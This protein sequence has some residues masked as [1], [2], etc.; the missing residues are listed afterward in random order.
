VWSQLG[1]HNVLNG[2]AAIAAARHAGVPVMVAIEALA[3]FRGVKRRLEL[4]GVVDRIAVYDDFAHHPTAIATTLA[5]LRARVGDDRVIAVLEPR[6]NT[7]RMG[8]FRDAL[9]A[10]LREAD[11]VVCYQA[12]DL[13]WELAPALAAL[14]QPVR[15]SGSI[16]DVLD[17]VITLAQPGD[18]VVIMSNGGFGGIHERLL[19]A[20]GSVSSSPAV[21]GSE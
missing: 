4:R 13:E 19:A 6:S 16:D 1:Y 7:M 2:L 21:V 10:A 14:E 3:R 12:P 15:V 17:A 8:L 18:H 5:G 11:A 20:L 9:A